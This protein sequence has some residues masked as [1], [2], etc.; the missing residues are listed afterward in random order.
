MAATLRLNLA[1]SLVLALGLWGCTSEPND[2]VDTADSDTGDTAPDPCAAD[3]HVVDH[4]CIACEPG[5]TRDA[6]D[7]PAGD[8]TTCEAI[9]CD[10]DEAVVDHQCI[11]CEPGTAN[12]AGDDATG[13]DTTCETVF[14]EIDEHVVDH[15][16]VACDE[17][18]YNDAGDD[19]TGDDTTCQLALCA[20]NEHVVDGAC[21]A[22]MPGSTN[23][24]DD[25]PSGPNTECDVE[26]CDENERVE[27]HACVA[28]AGG[29]NAPGDDPTGEDT[30][31]CDETPIWGAAALDGTSDGQFQNGFVFT[32]NPGSVSDTAWT[33]LSINEAGGAVTP[34]AAYWVRNTTGYSAGAYWGSTN[35][36]PSPTQANGVAIFDSDFLD[37]GGQQGAFGM[38]TSPSPHHGELISPLIDLTDYDEVPLTAVFFTGYRDFDIT[39]FGVSLSVNDGATWGPV[40]E[41]PLVGGIVT[42]ETVLPLGTLTDNLPQD[43]DL[44]QSRLKVVFNGDYYYAMVDDLTLYACYSP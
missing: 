38:G 9:L 26:F 33:A 13:D 40:Q 36:L 3:E 17:G 8:D 35:T 11:A 34:G 1:P 21:V 41:V 28:C 10:E 6:G 39:S 30:T 27:A 19:A 32:G 31:C 16:C 14:C 29:I 12:A 7:D 42:T 15:E 22:C 37:N 43:A 24:Q 20:E 2:T 23:A 18:S 44:T 25:D 4:E 5:S